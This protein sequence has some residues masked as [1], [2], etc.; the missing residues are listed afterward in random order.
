MLKKFELDTREHGILPKLQEG[1]FTAGWYVVP[2]MHNHINTL[3]QRA[4]N[5]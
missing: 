2:F 1:M 3:L 4:C 5:G